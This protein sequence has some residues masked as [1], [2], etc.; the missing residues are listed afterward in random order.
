[1][2]QQINN[3]P[4]HHNNRKKIAELLLQGK[5]LTAMQIAGKLHT[6]KGSTRCGELI[7][8]GF[9]IEKEPHKTSNCIV[10]SIPEKKR[11]KAAKLFRKIYG[12]AA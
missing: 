6:V 8:E 10:Y 9:P 2:V 1:M 3:S 5:K 11:M 4:M 7:R 12:Q